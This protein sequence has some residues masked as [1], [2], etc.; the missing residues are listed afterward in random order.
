MAALGYLAK[1][2]RVLGRAFGAHFL[3]DFPIKMFLIQFSINGQ[4]FSV[5]PHFFLKISNKCVIKFLLRQL[6]T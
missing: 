3:H 4:S 5:T 1:L 6:M 2:K